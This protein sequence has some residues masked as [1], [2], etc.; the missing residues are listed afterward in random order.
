M[1]WYDDSRLLIDFAK[2]LA[3]AGVVEDMSDVLDKPYKY[4]EEFDAW[5]EAGYPSEED[6]EWDDFVTAVKGEEE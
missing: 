4:D 2:A 5:K 1:A 3:W 6:T